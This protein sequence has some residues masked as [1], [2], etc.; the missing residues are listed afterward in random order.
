[1]DSKNLQNGN[2]FFEWMNGLYHPCCIVYTTIRAKNILTKNNLKPAEFLRPFGNFT[3]SN[4]NF[5]FGEKF[6]I[7]MKN[8]RIN[9]YDNEA[10]KKQSASSTNT[11]LEQVMVHNL[12][13][14]E[15]SIDKV[16]YL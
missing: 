5:S 11:L 14:A 9:F 16:I 13:K 4:I 10:Y 2:Y 8:L 3:G 1:M 6:T 7:N 12:S 15:W